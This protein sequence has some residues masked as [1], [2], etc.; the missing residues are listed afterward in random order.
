MI[1]G[2]VAV[3]VG[4][5]APEGKHDLAVALEYRGMCLGVGLAIAAG[6]LAVSS[7]RRLLSVT[8]EEPSGPWVKLPLPS[9]RR[10][11][12]S[13]RAKR[14]TKMS[15]RG[16]CLRMPEPAQQ[17]EPTPHVLGIG[18]SAK[19]QALERSQN[20]RQFRLVKKDLAGVSSGAYGSSA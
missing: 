5:R 20:R 15:G 16:Y 2:V 1:A 14:E 9:S 3:V 8:A 18:L 19:P 7:L 17:R 4:F 6:Y 13:E 12:T 11:G 10:G